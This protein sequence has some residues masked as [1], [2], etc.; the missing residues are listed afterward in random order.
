MSYIHLE[1]AAELILM[2]DQDHIIKEQET[3]MEF[4]ISIKISKAH[5]QEPFMNRSHAHAETADRVCD[6]YRNIAKYI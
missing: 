3:E 6:C 5:V 4:K 2:I 1:E